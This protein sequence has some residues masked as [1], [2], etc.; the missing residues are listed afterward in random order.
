LFFV[1]KNISFNNNIEFYLPRLVELLSDLLEVD[2]CSIFLYDGVKDQLYCKVITGRLREAITFDRE[3][4]NV[5]STVFNQGQIIHLKDCSTADSKAQ[6]GEYLTLNQKLH[7]VTKNVLIVPIKLGNNAIGCLEVANKKRN[8]E[9]TTNDA[10]VLEDVANSIA[11]GLIAHEMK[12]NIK[13]ESDEELRHVKGLMNQSLNSFLIPMI[14]EGTALCQQVL[15]AE[16][17][18]FF[19]YNK[20]IDHLYSISQKPN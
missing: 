5:L 12:Y 8:G 18:V 20:D 2:R 10:Q 17:V 15:K 1:T 13:K 14:S 11:S 16:K 4:H 7:T 9:F 19:M 3:K 6:M